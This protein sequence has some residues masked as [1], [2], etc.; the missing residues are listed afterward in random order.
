MQNNYNSLQ[1]ILTSLDFKEPDRVP[2]TLLFSYYGAKEL[3]IDIKDYFSHSEN[4]VEAQ[5]RLHEKFQSDSLF[6][7]FYASAEI[8]AYGGETIFVK[9]GT[10]N[11]STPIIQNLKDIENLKVP[12]IEES[13]VLMRVLETTRKL[14]QHA[15]QEIPI[16]GVAISPFSMPVMQMGFDKYLD[17]M[18]LHPE[19]FKKLMEINTEFYLNWANAQIEAGASMICYFD[20]VSSPS[21]IPSKL[22]YQKSFDLSKEC[23]SKTN[24]PVGT[25]FA[26][27]R[28][29]EL[30]P[31]LSETGTLLLGVSS[32]EDL[33]E[34][35]QKAQNKIALLGNLNGIEMCRWTEQETEQHVKDAIQK[36]GRGGGFILSDNHGE[37]PYHVS[38]KTLYKIAE[39][40]QKWG[41]YPL[42]WF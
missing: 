29:M 6:N 10:P 41:Q 2:Y 15:K 31:K 25:H 34:L 11:S 36:A 5:M 30:L 38:E 7:F 27:G 28:A 22:F 40:V 20:P 21:I 39:S 4:V 14:K 24:S 35:K 26:S 19:H 1:R 17:L 23:I 32:L 12:I 9:E 18:Y 37:I 33:A 13:P 3:G 8:E 16:L 42:N